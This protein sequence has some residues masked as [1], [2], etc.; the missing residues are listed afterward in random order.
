[1]NH[2]F[3]LFEE[4]GLREVVADGV[5]GEVAGEVASRQAI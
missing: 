2:L 3:K 1:M 5:G 4:N